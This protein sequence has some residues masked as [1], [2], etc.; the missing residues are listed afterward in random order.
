MANETAP[1]LQAPTPLRIFCEVPSGRIFGCTLPSM[2]NIG[3]DCVA[4]RAGG[5][6][7][8]EEPIP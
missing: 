3:P 4:Y 8:H 7:K 1:P 6:L 5:G 2:I